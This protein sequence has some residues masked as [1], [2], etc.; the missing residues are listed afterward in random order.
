VPRQNWIW[1]CRRNLRTTIYY[2][3]VVRYATDKYHSQWQ[4]LLGDAY[5]G[6]PSE[7]AYCKLSDLLQPAQFPE[8][9]TF[10]LDLW[11]QC[12]SCAYFVD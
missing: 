6:K 7:G 8:P 2:K 1:A 10:H 9:T 12:P 5:V 11:G 3:D 4:R